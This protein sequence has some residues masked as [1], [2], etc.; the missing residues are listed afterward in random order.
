MS[1]FH[2][3]R[4]DVNFHRHGVG[5]STGK[6]RW[7]KIAWSYARFFFSGTN[8]LS[9]R[10]TGGE[11]V[12]GHKEWLLGDGHV[13]GHG[14]VESTYSSF[15]LSFES[16]LEAE[17]TGG[18]DNSSTSLMIPDDTRENQRLIMLKCRRLQ[19]LER[20]I[21]PIVVIAGLVRFQYQDIL[22]ATRNFQEG[23]SSEWMNK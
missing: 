15:R 12:Y 16:Q 13:V 6:T 8:P 19:S 1:C 10:K 17:E 23:D 7:T 9:K 4:E 11:E 21:S 20:T 2:P 22:V 3:H 5:H 14:E 18:T